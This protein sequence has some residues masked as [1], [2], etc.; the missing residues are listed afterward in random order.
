MERVSH[1][2]TGIVEGVH[3]DAGHAFSK[4]ACGQIELVAG[5]GVAGDA[6]CGAT[7]RH[8]SRVA[9]DPDQPNL[10]QVHLVAGELHD[11]LR[12][13]GFTVGP[14]DMGENVTTRGID[15]LALPTGTVLRVGDGALLAVTG[16]RNPCRQLDGLQPGLQGAV[17]GRDDAGTLVRRAGIMA[18]VVF[19][20]TVAPGDAI[21][22]ATPPGPPIP[23]APV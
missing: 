19:G 1:D 5:L 21:L 10:R 20:G 3:R 6:H 11:E 15:L 2:L 16:L 14:G 4:P 18:V 23:L 9:A 13:R 7:V 17:L 12:E 22:V 8:L